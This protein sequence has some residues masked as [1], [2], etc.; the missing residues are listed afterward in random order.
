MDVGSSNGAIVGIYD[1][2]AGLDLITEPALSDNFRICMAPPGFQ[3]AY[4]L[5]KDQHLSS[6]AP[7]QSAVTL[8]W[9]GPLTDQQGGLFHGLSA[10]M[11]VEL[12]DDRVEFRLDVQNDTPHRMYEVWYPIV[13]G[14][15]G[16]GE[17]KD[18]KTY[19]PGPD[20]KDLDQQL[21]WNFRNRWGLEGATVYP[22]LFFKHPEHLGKLWVDIHNP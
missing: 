14:M 4:I 21:F 1:K 16:I 10:T 5:D 22:E 15:T 17:R 12:V 6:V 7:T 9:D 20:H 18:T 3:D 2:T 13:G 19:I 8:A 11:S